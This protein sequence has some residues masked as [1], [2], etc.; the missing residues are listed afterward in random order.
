MPLCLF[1]QQ[2]N[3]G[4]SVKQLIA[5]QDSLKDYG[6]KFINE[7]TEMERMN[8]NTMFIKTLVKALK[9]PHSFNFAFD[10]LK[11]VSIL[12]SPDNRYRLITWH[13]A[14]DDGSYR[15][16][17]TIQMNTEELKMYPLTDFSPYIKNAEDT[18][19]DNSRWLGAQY[20]KIIPVND[21]QNPYY[22][23]LGWKGYY[24][25]IDKKSH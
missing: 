1:G 6:K 16:Y 18:L 12:N 22:V 5:Y 19:T 25:K 17:G 13:V 14:F 23:L 7:G 2:P 21:G 10:S 15:F 11:S 4:G 20:Y 8:A 24:C 3:D 9:V